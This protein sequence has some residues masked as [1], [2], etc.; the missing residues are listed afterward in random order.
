M[1]ALYFSEGIVNGVSPKQGSYQASDHCLRPTNTNRLWLSESLLCFQ[2]LLRHQ[3]CFFRTCG[4]FFQ[5][6]FSSQTYFFF[7]FTC[8]C[9]FL[10]PKFGAASLAGLVAL[11]WVFKTKTWSFPNHNQVIFVSKPNHTFATALLNYNISVYLL[12]NNMQM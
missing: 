7:F 4:C 12:H 5:Q 8:D 10:A 11:N 9:S 1:L 2:Q 3:T 6:L